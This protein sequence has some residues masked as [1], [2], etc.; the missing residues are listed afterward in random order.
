MY[1]QI[2]V[3]SLKV[4]KMFLKTLYDTDFSLLQINLTD[5]ASWY[6]FVSINLHSKTKTSCL[7]SPIDIF[8]SFRKLLHLSKQLFSQKSCNFTFM[9]VT[10][11]TESM[12]SFLQCIILTKAFFQNK[13]FHSR[14]CPHPHF[15]MRL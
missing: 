1:W 9:Y 2:T 13:I 6:L 3:L 15:K 10:N 11:P 8:L 4:I 7:N 14:F 5:E 12:I